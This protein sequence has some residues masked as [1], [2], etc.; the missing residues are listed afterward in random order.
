MLHL[1]RLYCNRIIEEMNMSYS[2]LPQL[3][4]TL[5]PRTEMTLQQTL[6]V[7]LFPEKLFSNTK[8]A[9]VTRRKPDQGAGT[10]F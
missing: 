4:L 5:N 9:S 10:S 1:N 3:T 6:R 7:L 2:V 8:L